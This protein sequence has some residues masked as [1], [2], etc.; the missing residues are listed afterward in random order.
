MNYRVVWRPGADSAVLANLLRAADKPALWAVVRGAEQSLRLD[1]YA[2]GESRD[3]PAQRHAYFR[4][5]EFLFE[6][7]EPNR[8]VYVNAS[9][10]VGA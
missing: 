8:T 9:R 7:D 4:P 5:F 6:I 10:W 2:V 1:P 3:D